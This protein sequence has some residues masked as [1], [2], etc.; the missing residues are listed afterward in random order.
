[1]VRA[2]W[3][4]VRVSSSSRR[5]LIFTYLPQN[6]SSRQNWFELCNTAQQDARCYILTSGN[7]L[8]LLCV[9]VQRR[10]IKGEHALG[11]APDEGGLVPFAGF[12]PHVTCH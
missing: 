10:K 4:R 3:V 12:C 7:E 6:K 9:N 1:M 5:P 2:V 8:T 11:I